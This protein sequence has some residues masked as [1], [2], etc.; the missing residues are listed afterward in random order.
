MAIP[1]EQMNFERE[2]AQ[3]EKRLEQTGQVPSVLLHSCCA[4]CS[5]TCIA[6]LSEHFKVTVFYYNPNITDEPEYAKRAA[7]EQKFIKEFKAKNPVD[8][9]EG[10]YNPK[11]FFTSV[12]GYE[13]CPEGQDRCFICY[14]LRLSKTAE[15]AKAKE[16]DYF[17]TTL[18]LSPLKSAVKLNE[19]GFEEAERT[20]AVY[21]PTDFKKKNGYLKSC[22]M[23]KEY[24]LYRQQYCGCVY[25]LRRDLKLK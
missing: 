17:A 21:L 25:S 1:F 11:L 12:K 16:Y 13:S 22:E 18:T 9:L 8:Y 7:E 20:G 10:E 19:I 5:T 4:P 6:R 2:L 3:L 15:V 23:S 24:G 14:R